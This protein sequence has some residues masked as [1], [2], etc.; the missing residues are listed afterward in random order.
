SV[1]IRRDGPE[2]A[3]DQSGK[4]LH[5]LSIAGCAHQHQRKIVA[6]G[7]E[8]PVSGENRGTQATLGMCIECAAGHPPREMK[9]N[10]C[11]KFCLHAKIALVVSVLIPDILHALGRTPLSASW[12]QI[13]ILSSSAS[14]PALM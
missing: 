9:R 2:R 3:I 12:G 7:G 14:R 13:V 11:L 4:R 8:I 5:R 1:T 6:K 10:V